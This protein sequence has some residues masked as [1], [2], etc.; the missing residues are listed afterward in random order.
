MALVIAVIVALIRFNV[1]ARVGPKRR[2]HGAS[3]YYHADYWL[4]TYNVGVYTD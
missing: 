1:D 4:A 3:G 2:L